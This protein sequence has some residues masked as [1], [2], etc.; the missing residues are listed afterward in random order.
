[1]SEKPP[2]NVA[3]N[4]NSDAGTNGRPVISDLW[5]KLAQLEMTFT[6][7]INRLQST[8]NVDVRSRFV[9][10]MNVND[11]EKL[12]IINALPGIEVLFLEKFRLSWSNF[13][14]RYERRMSSGNDLDYESFS[15]IIENVERE[16]LSFDTMLNGADDSADYDDPDERKRVAN[17]VKSNEP[18]KVVLYNRIV[19]PNR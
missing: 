9:N 8:W 19:I 7:T 1:M 15:A 16:L 12:M 10:A 4:S 17:N 18:A 13:K 14:A 6:K 5:L 2:A 11:A 3:S